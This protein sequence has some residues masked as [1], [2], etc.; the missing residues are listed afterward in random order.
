MTRLKKWAKNWNR[1]FSKEDIQMANKYMK[2][3]QTPL[4]IREMQI[5]ITVMY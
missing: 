5:K 4:N 2:T 1:N 3:W